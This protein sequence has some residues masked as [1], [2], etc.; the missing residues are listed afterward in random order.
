MP[1]KPISRFFMTP[2]KKSMLRKKYKKRGIYNKTS[3][4]MGLG[5]PKRVQMTHKYNDIIRVN[6]GVAGQTGSYNFRCNSLFDPN[7]TATGHQPMYFDQL[8]AIYD[9]YTVIGAKINLRIFKAD[10]TGAGVY[11][12]AVVG[13]YINDD[14]SLVST[15]INTLCEHTQNRTRVVS[16]DKPAFFTLKWSA[17]K[18]FGGSILGNDN[19]QG[20]ATTNPTEE[21]YFTLFY[22]SELQTQQ[23]ALD[24]YVDLTFITIWDE[25]RDIAGS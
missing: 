6:T 9:H 24:V 23:V 12:N 1:K 14:S 3:V 13:C 18:T 15:N 25:L 7:Q 5:F 2:A 19:L 21:S 17:K 4:P 22:N 20:T 11:T 8:A 10:T 16:L